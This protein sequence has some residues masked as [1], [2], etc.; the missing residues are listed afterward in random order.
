MHVWGGWVAAFLG[1]RLSAATALFLGGSANIL[2]LGFL[3]TGAPS[4]VFVAA[5]AIFGFL[6]A[7]VLSFVTPFTLKTDPTGRAVMLIG[8]AEPFGA[9]AGPA[10]VSMAVCAIGVEAAPL[11]SAALFA[12]GTSNCVALKLKPAKLPLAVS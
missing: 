4:L 10:F 6:W 5:I 9:A 11:V 8:T 2:V 7:F 12:I 1:H 3:W